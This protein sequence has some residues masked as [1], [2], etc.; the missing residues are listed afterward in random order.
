MRPCAGFTAKSVTKSVT[1][2]LPM[3]HELVPETS[4]PHIERAR[5]TAGGKKSRGKSGN[6]ATRHEPLKMALDT[7]RHLD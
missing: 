2:F 1:K 7:Q 6:H 3:P 4:G 5:P